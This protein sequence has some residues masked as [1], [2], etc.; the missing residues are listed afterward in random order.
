MLGETIVINILG[1]DLRIID[2][3]NIDLDKMA[4]IEDCWG[5]FKGDSIYLATSLTGE[6]RK[7]VLIH[8]LTH[9]VLAISG[10]TNLIEDKLEEAICDAMESLTSAHL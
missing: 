2:I 9:A 6:Q 1:R 5:L 8:E 3:P 4:G 10:L 7:R